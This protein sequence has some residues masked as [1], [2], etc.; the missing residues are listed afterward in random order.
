MKPI[1][2]LT[3]RNGRGDTIAEL[4]LEERAGRPAERHERSTAIE[5]AISDPQ[6][7]MLFRLAARLGFEGDRARDYV[8]RRLGP[9][10]D[11]RTAS[12]LIDDLQDEVKRNNGGRDADAP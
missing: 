7:R 6:R 10:P 11:R 5:H 8:E 1:L 12:R 2:I 9:D 3:I 4:S